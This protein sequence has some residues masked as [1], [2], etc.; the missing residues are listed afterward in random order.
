M[1][2][3][4]ISELDH[5]VLN[6]GD[7]ERSLKFYTEVMGFELTTRMGD[8]AAFLS[9]GGVVHRHTL[10]RTDTRRRGAETKWAG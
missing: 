9:A 3:F 10:I 6:V 4:K 8:S 2:G 7:I 1:S 5:I